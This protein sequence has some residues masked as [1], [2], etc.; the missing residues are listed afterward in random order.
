MRGRLCIYTLLLVLSAGGAAAQSGVTIINPSEARVQWNHDGVRLGYF[1]YWV[2]NQPVPL[3]GAYEKV[4]A[5]TYRHKLPADLKS[6]A[7]SVQVRACNLDA[8]VLE[9]CTA[10]LV[11]HFTV[12]RGTGPVILPPGVPTNLTIITITTPPVTKKP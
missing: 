11:V 12:D 1:D 4:D 7:H 2:D 9:K 10:W 5:T 8:T 3:L 6:G